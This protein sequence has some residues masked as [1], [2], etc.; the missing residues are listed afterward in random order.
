MSVGTRTNNQEGK[1]VQANGG[2]RQK[3]TKKHWSG[4]ADKQPSGH[5]GT[6]STGREEAGSRGSATTHLAVTSVPSAPKFDPWMDT[7]C[8]PE[9]APA[10]A[11]SPSNDVMMGGP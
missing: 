2:E 8:P 10:V 4:D 11:P 9:V 3:S 6:R 7:T 1:A 5:S